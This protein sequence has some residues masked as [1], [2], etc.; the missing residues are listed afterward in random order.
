MNFKPTQHAPR[1]EQR[2]VQM[3]HNPEGF[4][5]QSLRTFYFANTKTRREY[6][7][8]DRMQRKTRID[9]VSL[10]KSFYRDVDVFSRR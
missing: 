6:G 9:P 3:P 2:H 1:A 8:E 5:P 10:R 4:R 7:V